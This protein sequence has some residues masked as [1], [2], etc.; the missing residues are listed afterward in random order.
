MQKDFHYDMVYALA[1]E[2]GYEDNEA[3]IIAHSS[4]YVDDNTDREYSAYDSYGEFYV[5]FSE[6]IGKCRR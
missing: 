3:Y 4:Q 5:D 2:A 6:T 1:K